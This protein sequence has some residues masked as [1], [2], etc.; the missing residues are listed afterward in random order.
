MHILLLAFYHPR[1][2]EPMKRWGGLLR[3]KGWDVTEM[4]PTDYYKEEVLNEFTKNYDMIVYFGHGVPGA[5]CGY[6]F[7]CAD[8]FEKIKHGSHGRIILSLCCFSLC[9]DRG[10][11]LG[12][13]FISNSLA[14]FVFGYKGSIR[15]DEN[16]EV[17]NRIFTIL[18]DTD[19]CNFDFLKSTL[20]NF[21]NNSA[22]VIC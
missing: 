16:L 17:L 3:R 14:S 5:W 22:Q 6:G 2:M 7:I 21:N 9:E 13:A 20:N 15:Y 1:Y 12:D 19:E 11:S 8:D 4:Y 18:T 10:K